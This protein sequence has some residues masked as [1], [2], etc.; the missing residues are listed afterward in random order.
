MGDEMLSRADELDVET[1]AD[2]TVITLE[3]PAYVREVAC[4]ARSIEA[5]SS[6]NSRVSIGFDR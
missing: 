5:T 2:E 6:A 3:E 1:A 4:T